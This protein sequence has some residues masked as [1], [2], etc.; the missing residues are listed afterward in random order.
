MSQTA[1]RARARPARENQDGGRNFR[2]YISQVCVGTE[3]T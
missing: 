3:A 2:Y 1:E